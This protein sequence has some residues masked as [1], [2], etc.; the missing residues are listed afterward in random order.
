MVRAP[1]ISAELFDTVFRPVMPSLVGVRTLV[2][3]ADA[4]YQSVAFAGLWDRQRDRYV[5]EDRAIVAA[6]SATA[7]VWALARGRHVVGQGVR[8]AIVIESPNGD[9]AESNGS[10]LRNDSDD[11]GVAALY[12]RAEVRRGEAATAGRLNGETRDADVIH[13]AAPIY[14]NAEFPSL[15][16]LLLAD[17]PG[18]KHSG[19]VFAWDVADTELSQARLVTLEGRFEGRANSSSQ[20]TLAFSRALLAAGVPNVVGLVAEVK[21]HSLRQPWLDFHRHYVAGMPAAESLRQ[22]QLAALSDSNHRPGPWALLTVF[23][24]TQ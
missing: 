10:Y 23:G 17:A 22:A 7:Y 15:S 18:Q 13:V 20:G 19:A 4:P 11:G 6:P 16:R 3:V 12:A 14:H 21:A 24:S 9:V 2:V 5:V 8:E 1:T